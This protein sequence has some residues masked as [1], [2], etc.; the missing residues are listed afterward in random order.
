M[1]KLILLLVLLFPLLA[2]G[3]IV[4]HSPYTQTWPT[5]FTSEI[6]E[7]NR[8]I[9]FEPNTIT[10]ATETENGKDIEVLTVQNVVQ[11]EGK[12]S[13]FCTTRN[14]QNVTIALPE[15]ERVEII[16]YYS[17][18]PKTKEEYQL[19]FYVERVQ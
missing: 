14:N 4:F 13:I 6:E 9:S 8:R 2:S 5:I 12:V 10:I 19:R 3:Q 17:Q 1:T 16:D 15:Q 18:D 11:Y 7:V